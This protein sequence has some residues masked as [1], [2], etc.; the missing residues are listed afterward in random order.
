MAMTLITTNTSSDSAYMSFTSGIDS[1][2]KLYIFKV[3]DFNPATNSGELLFMPSIDGG[4]N[5]NVALTTTF[6]TSEHSE[7]DSS[8]AA[9][10]YLTGYDIA[11]GTS[12][13]YWFKECGSGGDESA[14]GTLWLFNPSNTTYV[15]HFFSTCQGYKSNDVSELA[16]GAG[17]ANT[18]S[19]VNAIKF[20]CDRSNFSATIKMYGVG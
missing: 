18:T 14:A 16:F 17:Y 19:A 8:V 13:A 3:I 11:Q 2:Y 9:L 5:W 10:T 4:S 1:T 15:K 6:F 12:H 7:D 20:W